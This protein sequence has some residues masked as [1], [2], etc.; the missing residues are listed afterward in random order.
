M[1]KK[2]EWITTRKIPSENGKKIQKEKIKNLFTREEKYVI[3]YIN[4]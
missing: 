1:H 3:L 2:L 4:V